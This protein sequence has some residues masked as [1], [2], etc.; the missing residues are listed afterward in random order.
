MPDSLLF[1]TSGSA[2]LEPVVLSNAVSVT[3][4]QAAKMLSDYCSASSFSDDV[5][6][7]DK[8]KPDKNVKPSSRNIYFTG[9]SNE[10]LKKEA[11][12]W[13]LT[14]L[15]KGRDPAAISSDICMSIKHCADFIP[16]DCKSFAEAPPEALASFYAYLI[17]GERK[18]SLR[19]RL[20]YWHALEAFARESGFTDISSAMQRFVLER[21]PAYVK[22]E[23]KYIPDEVAGQLDVIFMKDGIPLVYRCIYWMLRLIPNRATEVLSMTVRCLKRLDA[24]TYTLT[25][26]SFKQSGPYVPSD[27]KLIEVRYEGMGKLLVDLVAAQ[28][29]EVLAH[30]GENARWLFTSRAYR[31]IRDPKTGERCYRTHGS[32]FKPKNLGSCNHFFSR[33]CEYRGIVDERG[34]PYSPTTH[35]FRHN[36]V[37]DRMN[38]GLFRAIDLL[39][40]TAHHNTKMIEQSYTHTSVKDLRKD[41]PVVFRGRIINTDDPAR[42]DR[43]LS[44]PFAK[45]VHR[46]GLCSDAGGCSADRSRCLRCSY[47]VPD[48]GDLDYYQNE[49]DDW[50]SKQEKALS[51]GNDVFAELCGAW[52]DAYKTLIQ[53]V[54][55]AISGEDLEVS[56]EAAQ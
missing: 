38:S 5:W 10:H 7:A 24:D 55:S 49:L 25:I 14:R 18:T 41:D 33:L 4:E 15:V 17:S 32:A 47:L 19:K 11:K 37:S 42:F 43:I 3:D 51:C 28:R 45:R 36:A 48:A 21:A 31:L 40:L 54:L 26:P 34:E 35:Q 13:A 6:Q 22:K 50:R 1:P 56:D 23:D 46:I 12:R 8:V 29:D 20:H 52:I 2:A 39:P 30:L 53:R 44:K 9:I 16:D 27:I